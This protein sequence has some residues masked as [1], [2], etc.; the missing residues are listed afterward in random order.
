MAE[1]VAPLG[2]GYADARTE[3]IGVTVLQ[4]VPVLTWA[5]AAMNYGE[6]P[7]S[8]Q[9]NAEADVEGTFE[10]PEMSG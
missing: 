5:P 10:Y 4:A 1:Y 7:T 6:A 8:A 2:G 9:M 3:W